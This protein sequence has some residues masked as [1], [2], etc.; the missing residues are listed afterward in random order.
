MNE[1]DKTKMT[2][3]NVSTAIDTGQSSQKCTANSI[4][5]WD[6]NFNSSEKSFEEPLNEKLNSTSMLNL[7]LHS[8]LVWCML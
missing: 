5:D 4:A 3:P 8:L 1:A 7:V 6:E 2:A